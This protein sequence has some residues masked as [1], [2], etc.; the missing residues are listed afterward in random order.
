MKTIKLKFLTD[1]GKSFNISM[2][3]AADALSAEGGKKMI[4]DAMDAVLVQQPFVFTLGSKNGAEL[5]ERNVTE[6]VA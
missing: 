1:S 2:N 6:I 3:Y 5:I 4:E